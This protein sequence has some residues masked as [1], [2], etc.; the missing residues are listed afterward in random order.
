MNSYNLI[1]IGGGAGA[2]A[3]AIE[4]NRR[5]AKTAM[6]NAGLPV[7]GT[8]VNVGC[9]P[10]KKLLWAGEVLHTAKSH[11]ID[12]L[13]IDVKAL[14]FAKIVA[15]ER[16]LVEKMRKD[17][18]ESLLANLENVTYIESKARFVSPNE[19]EVKGKAIKGDTFVIATGSTARVPDIAGIHN[20]GYLT[21]IEA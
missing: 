14:N 12:G 20:V 8:C 13:E 9:V 5:G 19:V 16:A 7:G 6:I 10:S 18:Y 4:A 3:A 11:G 2:F 21:H 17:K 15:E 1:I